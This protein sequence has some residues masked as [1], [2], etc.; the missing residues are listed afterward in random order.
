LVAIAEL[1]GRPPPIE[2]LAP[3]AGAEK[4]HKNI[5]LLMLAIA[6]AI[7]AMISI[8]PSTPNMI[9]G[10][11][12]REFAS[13]ETIV[14]L[15]GVMSGLSGFG[16]SAIG[17]VS[18]LF[19]S[20][21]LQVPLFQALSTGNQML[22]VG[23]LRKDMPKTRKEMWAGP[24]PYM[25]GGAAGV[26]IGIWLLTHLPATYLMAIFG[27]LLT[28]YAAYSI[29][30]PAHTV[31]RGF[32]A[33]IYGVVVGFMGGVMG[34]FTA[35]PGA[36]VVV[37]SGLR[38]LSKERHRSIVQP[39]ILLSQIYSL[40]LVALWHSSYLD[41]R[42]FTLLILTLPVVVPGTL[43]GLALY[44]RTS[45]INFK[46]VTYLLLGASGL[47]LLAKLWFPYLKVLF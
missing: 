4:G 13:I 45:D 35:F 8:L 20:P 1:Q 15:S 30:K 5:W 10:L 25:L 43:T 2:T 34:G 12:L 18:L 37:W 17:A 28:V 21:M 41:T 24:G 40:A 46:R 39:Y 27:M 38:G 3:P 36:A 29:W 42:Y 31:L 14:F 9:A 7:L 23:Q 44:R 47:S 11:S 32:D 19:L 22:S 6:M 26:P 33:P 16:F